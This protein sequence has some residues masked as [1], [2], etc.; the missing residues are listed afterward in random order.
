M[1]GIAGLLIG[2]VVLG[3]AGAGCLGVARLED[4]MADA[5]ERLS[6]LQYTAAEESLAQAELDAGR[7]RWVPWLGSDAR[8]EIQARRAALRYW[9]RQYETVV[10]AQAEPVTAVDDTNLELQLVVANSLYRLGQ[11]RTEDRQTR[12]K[13]LDEAASGYL[14][15]LKNDTWHPDAAFN[16]EYVLRLRDGAAKGRQP[17]SPNDDDA[18]LG[19]AGGPSP[20]TSKGGFQIY[21]PLDKGERNP[22]GGEAGK[23][24]PRERK[25]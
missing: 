16:Y 7:A 18:D 5:G 17:P 4:R 25:G 21:I 9:E 14:T 3:L 15:V 12:I 19:E 10:P 2:A 13:T 1:K 11:T 23:V 20:A 6:T 22:E 8:Q 24:P